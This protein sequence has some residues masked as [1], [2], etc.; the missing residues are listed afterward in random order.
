MLK[1]TNS[2]TFS[3]FCNN[4]TFGIQ[5]SP[6]QDYKKKA[7]PNDT[8]HALVT[9]GLNF[10]SYN[11]DSAGNGLYLLR[12]FNSKFLSNIIPPCCQIEQ[13]TQ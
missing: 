8:S 7:V 6:A 4:I 2:I 11:T 12:H 10:V 5:V 9:H 3:N 13:L 1:S